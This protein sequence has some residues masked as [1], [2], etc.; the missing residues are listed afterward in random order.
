MLHHQHH[1]RVLPP[2]PG[3]LAEG[4]WTLAMRMR[5]SINIIASRQIEL[6]K[7]MGMDAYRFS[8]SWLRIFPNGSGQLHKGSNTTTTS[9]IPYWK[10]ESSPMQLCI[11]GIF[12][13]TDT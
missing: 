12:H 8:I 10:K 7:N 9:L 3:T 11:I 13:S 2:P 5:P 4:Y 6:M 1:R